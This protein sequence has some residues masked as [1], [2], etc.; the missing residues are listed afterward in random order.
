M[1]QELIRNLLTSANIT[2]E[3]T[4]E[5]IKLNH[6]DVANRKIGILQGLISVL[7]IVT[8]DHSKEITTGV[9]YMKEFADIYHRH[10]LSSIRQVTKRCRKCNLVI[11]RKTYNLMKKKGQRVRKIK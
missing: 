5:Q 9:M 10:K 1:K 8:C 6:Q 4:Q 3:E 2:V 11:Y 7:K